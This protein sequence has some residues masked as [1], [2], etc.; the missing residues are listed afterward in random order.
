MKKYIIFLTLCSFL[1]LCGCITEYEAKDIDKMAD[2]LVVDGII[3]DNETVITLKRSMNLTG[4]LDY[5]FSDYVNHARVYVECDDGT[6]WSADNDY[7]YN[8]QY[9][10]R[11]GQLNPDR[12]YRLKIEIDEV[13]GDC[14][15]DP[16][17]RSSCPNKTYEYCSVYSYPIR[18]PEIDS[19]FW[20]KRG[21]EQPVMIHVATHSLNNEILYYR[22]S[23]KEDW[24]IVSDRSL[25]P[26]PVYCWNKASSNGLLIGS[27]EKTVFGRLT[28]KLTEFPPYDRRLSHLYRIVVNQNAISKRAYD[29]FANIR[30]N[31]ENTGSI[32]A[33]IPSELRGNITC[34]T[35]LK[36]PVIGYIDVSSATQKTR[37][38]LRQD[39]PYLYEQPRYD[40]NA[41]T[42][43]KVCEELGISPEF[44]DTY[45]IPEDWV[46]YSYFPVISYIKIKCVDCTFYGTT[47]K[48]EDWPNNH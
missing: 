29:Y 39:Y 24:E 33:P 31:A 44:C 7:G 32:F 36:R 18:T 42:K 45:D 23:Y 1:I 8:G 10:V 20:L 13:D 38:I 48:P 30:R 34:T 40:C 16:W 22:W 35:D 25:E 41:L 12:K 17:S 5:S 26:Y 2:I 28:D 11:L 37:Y 15:Y 9:T 14:I 3:S 19:I 27:A 47:Q 6:Q 21:R 43:E 46:V 4:E